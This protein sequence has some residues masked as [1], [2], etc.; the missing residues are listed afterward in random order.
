MTDPA[1][2]SASRPGPRL[3][4]V[5]PHYND[6]ARL[7]RCLAALDPQVAREIGDGIEVVVADN[8]ST[9][10]LGPVLSRFA[11]ARLVIQ[12]EKGAGPA[13]N[14]GAAATAAPWIAFLDAD[15]RPAPDWI[16][17]VRRIAD[18]DAQAVTG[19]RI[20]VFDETPPPR[21][22]AEAFE[23][24]FAFD[25]AG[26]IRD[27]GFSVTANL[28]TARAVFDRTGPFRVGLS[29]DLEWCRRA[30]A[31]G[32][33]L[34]YDPDLVV[35][36]PTRQDWPALARKWRRLTA[37][38]YGLRAG[39]GQGRLAWL[40][41]ALVMPVSALWHMPRILRDTRLSGSEKARGALTLMRLR[42]ARMIW[43]L[44]HALTR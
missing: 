14:A 9:E 26:Y 34:V 13:R 16:A 28:V 10:D 2:Q 8:A 36:H 24:V 6:T 42:G 35:S 43:M 19:G 29:E 18:G 7:A 38:E 21:S 40:L 17:Q 31:E 1:S 12:T 15:C 32:A 4:V 22:G 41:K 25:Q 11:W 30:T 20:D 33:R 37:E 3:A 5:I 23:T 27:K 44:G 39:Q